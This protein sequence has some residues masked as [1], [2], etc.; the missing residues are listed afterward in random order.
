MRME[1]NS[2]SRRSLTPNPCSEIIERS[3]RHSV[4]RIPSGR[5]WPEDHPHE[6]V[7][8]HRRH[9]PATRPTP[10]PAPRHSRR[11]ADAGR[12][13]T[14]CASAP[15]RRS[16]NPANRAGSPAIPPRPHAS[17]RRPRPTPP[18]HRPT[19]TGNRPPP[20][21]AG[22]TRKPA[23]QNPPSANPAPATTPAPWTPATVPQTTSRRLRRSR[24][25]P[26]AAPSRPA[27]CTARTHHQRV[28]PARPPT[29]IPCAHPR[30][31][32]PPPQ[33]RRSAHPDEKK[34]PR[35]MRL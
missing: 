16:P 35:I 9:Y 5:R 11:A 1:V 18:A 13:T 22:P 20:D 19:S 21:D 14:A 15:P 27:R 17:P 25:H 24:P 29:T 3:A 33:A 31:P 10:T 30:P 28:I 23:C 7:R 4:L 34:R 2:L 6:I 32:L 26:A 8:P 12:R